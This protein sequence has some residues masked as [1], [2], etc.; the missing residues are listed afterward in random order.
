MCGKGLAA[1]IP[2]GGGL[3]QNAVAALLSFLFFRSPERVPV[4]AK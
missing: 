4:A 2:F 1:L 3:K